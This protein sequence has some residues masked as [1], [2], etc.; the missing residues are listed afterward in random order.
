VGEAVG[1]AEGEMSKI[2]KERRME[3]KECVTL[4]LVAKE[5][6]TREEMKR[7]WRVYGRIDSA[8]SRIV[9]LERVSGVADYWWVVAQER[10]TGLFH[11][12][13]RFPND[14]GL[15]I[16]PYAMSQSADEMA[17]WLD[18]L[19]RTAREGA[20]HVGLPAPIFERT[21]PP[22][23]AGEPMEDWLREMGWHEPMEDWLR[24]MPN[25][26]D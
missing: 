16:P 11:G 14:V 24:G 7:A 1:E 8:Q 17:N 23:L 4:K 13:L 15:I 26:G 9:L 12:Q 5:S 20:E 19:E 3:T 21:Q 6:A 18:L 10:A 25:G 22:D 2:P